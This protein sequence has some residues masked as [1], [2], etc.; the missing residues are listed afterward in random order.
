VTRFISDDEQHALD[1]AQ[2]ELDRDQQE[3]A[4]LQRMTRL[5]VWVG[6]ALLAITAAAFA[7][8]YGGQR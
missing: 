4:R 2:R 7:G 3:H 6:F 8:W 5:F 1:S